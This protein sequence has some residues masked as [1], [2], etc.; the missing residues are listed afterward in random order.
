MICLDG[1]YDDYGHYLCDY[2]NCK[3]PC[4]KPISKEEKK[5]LDYALSM[6]LQRQKRNGGSNQN[7]KEK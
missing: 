7:A 2:P 3:C 5:Y 1:C 4:H 6:S